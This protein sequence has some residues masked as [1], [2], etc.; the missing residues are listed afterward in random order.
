MRINRIN[1][2]VTVINVR[3]MITADFMT[4]QK[5]KLKLPVAGK[6]II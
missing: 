6:M 2:C 4:Q 5:K 3:N 1:Q